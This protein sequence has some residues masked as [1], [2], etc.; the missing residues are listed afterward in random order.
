MEGFCAKFQVFIAGS[1][2]Y[3]NKS[4][5]LS[6]VREGFIDIDKIAVRVDCFSSELGIPWD[7]TSVEY[8]FALEIIIGEIVARVDPTQ[9][10]SSLCLR[11][12]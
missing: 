5:S 1:K 11:K 4:E 7:A 3:F 8:A 10:I 9:V 12:T 6:G 2:A